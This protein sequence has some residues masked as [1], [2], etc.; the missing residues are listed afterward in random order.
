MIKMLKEYLDKQDVLTA[1]I[2][3]E[4][5]KL[6]NSI[7][8]NIPNK[9]KL[10]IA[11][12]ELMLFASQLRKPILLPNNT[13]I[14]IN[15]ISFVL[16]DSGES[17]DRTKNT[18]HKCFERG[19]K[20]I[21]VI[22]EQEAIS[23]AQLLAKEAGLPSPNSNY[24][25]FYEAPK[26]LF[27]SIGT[28]E[29]MIKYMNTLESGRFGS[30]YIYSGEFGS[31]L[32]TSSTIVENIRLLSEMYDEGKKEVKIIKS[33]ENQSQ[34]INNLPFSA[35]FIGSHKNILFDDSI[36]NKFKLEFN[37]KLARRSFFNFN[38]KPMK[39]IVF[40]NITDLIE[41]EK[42]EAEVST[43]TIQEFSQL[44]EEVVTHWSMS[45]KEGLVLDKDTL[46]IF[47][48]YKRYNEAVSKEIP[49]EYPIYQLATKHLYWKALKLAG[50][51]AVMNKTHI[52]TKQIYASAISFTEYLSSDL[53]EFEDELRKEKYEQFA[54]YLKSIAEDGKAVV[55]IHQIRKLGYI[56]STSVNNRLKELTQLANSYDEYGIYTVTNDTVEYEQLEHTDIIGASFFQI[57]DMPVFTEDMDNKTKTKLKE[58][59][60]KSIGKFDYIESTFDNL[61]ALMSS[62][63][64]YSPFKFKD[65]V[66]GK[67]NIISSTKWIVFDID[68]NDAIDWQSQHIILSEYNHHIAKSSVDTNEY[69]YRI[70]LELSSSVDL[71]S[72]Q[73]NLFLKS[74]ADELGIKFDKLPKSQIFYGYKGREVLSVTDKKTID[75][76]PH[77]LIAQSD[78]KPQVKELSKKEK[79]E[80]LND[81]FNTFSFAYEATKGSKSTSLVRAVYYAQ[82]LGMD[83]E[84]IVKLINDIN[85][86]YE[87]PLSEDRIESI[88]KQIKVD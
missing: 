74:I 22:R 40:D 76:K 18:V 86:Y 57:K 45:D 67:D 64:A 28:I 42:K 19:Y 54:D 44:S 71:S 47:Y 78:V 53:K 34:P 7:T 48:A 39:E 5:E 32:Q 83:K 60:A 56:T 87:T 52:I 51:I 2:P 79:H 25:K 27:T 80:K 17:K 26:P 38:N 55:P 81:L 3:S 11:M 85:N 13:K 21:N 63:M 88:L 49:K 33:D 1:L 10:T 46:D 77:L 30:A 36:K 37:T 16:A 59:I 84:G 62:D 14:P 72:H 8:G 20:Q 70:M 75:I 43:K 9:M 23:K 61:Y 24:K 41:Y 73:Y 58:Q 12:S 50:A 65:G 15:A 31:E 6:K 35:L 82:D 69:K 4:L 68:N 66:R 29:G